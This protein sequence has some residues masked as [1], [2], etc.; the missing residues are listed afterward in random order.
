MSVHRRELGAMRRVLRPAG[1][2]WDLAKGTDALCQASILADGSA[3]SVDLQAPGAFKI[4]ENLRLVTAYSHSNC[5]QKR[6]TARR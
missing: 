5:C 3:R 2:V 1:A 6:R 4:K